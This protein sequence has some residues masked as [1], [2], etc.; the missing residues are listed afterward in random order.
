MKK[1]LTALFL[2]GGLV[3]C[4]S[5]SQEI[6]DNGIYDMKAVQDYQT[7]IKTGNTVNSKQK[8]TEF[9]PPDLKVNASDSQLKATVTRSIPVVVPQ[10]G[11][12]YYHGYRYWW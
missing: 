9:S 11:I 2:I 5:K 12:G 6:T 1:I 10:I 4:S 3:G 7:R 8:L